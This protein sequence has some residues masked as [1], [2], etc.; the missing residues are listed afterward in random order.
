[1]Y[2]LQRLDKQV[3]HIGIAIVLVMF[4]MLGRLFYLQIIRGSHY[5]VRGEKNF[6]R[7]ETI[8]P[9]RGNIFD[10]HH[11]LLATNRPVNH[12]LWQGTGNR[13]LSGSQIALIR[14]L[15]E[16][17]GKPLLQASSLFS[18]ACAAERYYRTII[19]VPDITLEQLSKI[20]E[21]Y[22]DSPNLSIRTEFQRFYPY[23]SCA[24]HII[25]YLSK[26]LETSYGQMGIE[27]LCNDLLKGHEGALL[28]TINSVGR[29]IKSEE[30]ASAAAGLDIHT[31]ID[32][33]LQQIAETI[34]PGERTGCLAVMDPADGAIKALVS[35]PD[36]DPSLFLRPILPSEW[37]ELQEKKPFLNR[38]LN[39][40]PPGSI[41][42]LVTISAALE[43]G[44]LSP[45]QLWHCHGYVSFAGRKYYCNRRSG[46]GTLSLLQTIAQSCNILF[47]ETGKRLDI[48]LIAQYAHKFGLGVPTG[49]SLPERTGLVPCRE[50]KLRT[51]GERWWPGETLSVAI[52]QSFLM[53][54][55][56]QIARMVGGICSGHLVKPRLLVD[57]EPQKI[58]LMLH[59][60]TFAIL[61]ESMRFVITRGTGQRV[62]TVR[63]MEIYAKTSTAQTADF[64]KRTLDEKFLEHGWFVAY[65]QYKDYK[66]LVVV[67][68]VEN[69]GS[70]QVATLIA[71][72]FLI[73]YKEVAAQV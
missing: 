21:Y 50:W 13:T 37:Q 72:Q 1:V 63:D 34:F 66:P 10:C 48:D 12:L 19:I 45:D 27:K 11:K 6:L 68:L 70:A 3:I 32:I 43:H 22:P 35:R 47:F 25:G 61:K 67:I 62:N 44:Y 4:I 54:T 30:L 5:L 20:T 58:P 23:S 7:T 53:A 18:A 42:K 8:P 15:E 59:P 16:I 31:T 17:T 29:N 24:S 2:H 9:R 56:L 40:Y 52:G 14:H 51:K 26:S 38:A 46:H 69:A 65:F 36:F 49:I 57:E 64:E 28:K 60:T 73:L 41:F 55:P 33:E 39:S 71:K